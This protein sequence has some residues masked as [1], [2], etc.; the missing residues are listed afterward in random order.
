VTLDIRNLKQQNMKT[1]GVLLVY[2]T[3]I[4]NTSCKK[5][6]SDEI[7]KSSLIGV[8]QK[9]P[10][11]S[12]S[13]ISVYEMDVSLSQTGKAYTSQ[14]INNKGT[15]Q[16]SNVAF[17]YPYVCLR[18]D[19]F[20]FN[21][22]TGTQSNSQITLYAYSDLT[23][24]SSI[25]VNILSHLEKQR[26]EYL[27]S[28]GLQFDL[29]KKQA[30]REVLGVFSITKSDLPESETLDLTK[31]GDDNA[32]LLA[33]SLIIQGY[34]TEAEM[35]EL[36]SNISLDIQQDG[37][38]D[39]STLGTDLINHA[40]I[41]NLGKIRQNIQSRWN[42]LGI[43]DTIS[44]FEYYINKFIDST[45]YNFNNY[46]EYPYLTEYG[47]NLLNDSVTQIISINPDIGND[48]G[49]Y[50][51][52]TANLKQ[53]HSLK[54]VL[55]MEDPCGIPPG[56][57]V[58]YWWIDEIA[59][60]TTKNWVYTYYGPNIGGD[61]PT[62]HSQIFTSILSNEICNVRIRFA[63]TVEPSCSLRVDVYENSSIVPTKTKY[64]SVNK[65]I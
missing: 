41:L 13:S 31:S 54:I 64:I 20:Y 34:R 65:K 43:T 9:G 2:L 53:G 17:T 5:E 60:Y 62:E 33:I 27:V 61:F 48:I 22:I 15:F 46:I 40:K 28:Q 38:L 14:I 57:G 11:I 12:G 63:P 55:S 3:I 26:I 58:T 39:E 47:I 52:L 6:N 51:S 10:F 18:A 30:E 32:I 16:L 19:G 42:T 49:I 1:I 25:N 35:T 36:L 7:T 29:A 44:N 8:V 24:K 23:N 45:T 4:L 50:Y 59:P 21:E 56:W 37:T